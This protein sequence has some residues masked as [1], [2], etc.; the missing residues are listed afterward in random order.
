MIKYTR[1]EI[2]RTFRDRRFL[3]FSVGFPVM[4]Y[5]LWT[6]VFG[7]DGSSDK[8]TGLTVDT[9]MMVAFGAYGAIG[10]ALSTTGPR[11]ATELQDGWL[12]QLQV[13]PLRS[14]QVIS[15]R[16]V[17]ALTVALPS[18]LLVALTAVITKGVSLSAAQWAGTVVAL[19][20]GVLPFAALGTLIGATVKGDSAQPAMLMV[21][22]PLAIIGGLWVPVSNLPSFLQDIAP[23]TPANRMAELGWDIVGGNGVSGAG[24]LVLVVWTAALGALATFGYRRATVAA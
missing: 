18:M 12:R 8:T 14:W 20:L 10:A 9:Y 15:A 23:Y 22:F 3:F 1:L 6:N 24:V 13:T 4:L 19:T 16:I 5:L 17:T 7:D 2:L 21:Y 11:L